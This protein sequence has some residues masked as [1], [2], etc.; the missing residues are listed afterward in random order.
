LV[1]GASGAAVEEKSRNG[2]IE[3]NRKEGEE[4]EAV[5]YMPPT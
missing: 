3:K 1:V 5:W 4:V 2:M